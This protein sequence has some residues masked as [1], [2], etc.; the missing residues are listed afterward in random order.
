MAAAVTHVWTYDRAAVLR[1]VTSSSGHVFTGPACRLR[2]GLPCSLP[3]CCACCRVGI[4][5][6]QQ[7]A[8]LSAARWVHVP[9][10]CSVQLQQ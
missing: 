3:R 4:S 9:E 10:L 2:L 6:K 8:A 7:L 1:A 5:C